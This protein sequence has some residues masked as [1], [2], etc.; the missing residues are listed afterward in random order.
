MELDENLT[1]TFALLVSD[2]SEENIKDVDFLLHINFRHCWP[3]LETLTSRDVLRKMME[4]GMWNVDMQLKECCL[5]LLISLLDKIGRRDLSV[6][7]QN[8]GQ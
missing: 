6:L 3:R 8:L 4:L 7:L 5:S 1:S 2:L